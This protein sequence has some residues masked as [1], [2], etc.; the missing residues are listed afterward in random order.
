[1]LIDFA[2]RKELVMCRISGLLL[3]VL[4]LTADRA[5][6][7]GSL[8]DLL[9]PGNVV[10]DP[11]RFQLERG[12]ARGLDFPATA[13]TPGFTY[14]YDPALGDFRR[15]SASLGPAFLERADTV[16]KGR[17]D[18]GLSMLYAA[19]DEIDGHGL[20]GD[21][22]TIISEAPGFV[23][24]Q[25]A[26]QVRFDNFDLTA[27]SWYG[28]ATYGITN[29]IDV[30]LLL[31]LF[32][33][34]LSVRRT[35][36]FGA[37]VRTFSGSESAFGVGDIQVRGKYLI[38]RRDPLRAAVGLAFRLPTGNEDDFHGIGDF[39]ITPSGVLS[40]V[41]GRNDVHASLGLEM[42]ADEIERSRVNYGAG[43]SV[44]IIQRLTGNLDIIGSSQFVKEDVDVPVNASA[45]ALA[46]AVA[47]IPGAD[48][49][50]TGFNS[51]IV[52]LSIDRTDIVDVAVGAKVAIVGSLVGFATVIVPITD[53]GVRSDFVPAGGLEI[54]F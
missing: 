43:V 25:Q 10:V 47:R 48:V 14:Q 6:L 11:V 18:V 34:D 33:T 49:T 17:F 21:S 3:L 32:Y 7:A 15:T 20:D 1:M 35:D 23:G 40:Y 29:R 37:D 52:S 50:A 39:T 16:G 4:A 27:F 9:G 44:G 28:S 45:Q 13:T 30:N 53:D 51:S 8:V 12:L 31:P 41:F 46:P 2:P 42:N 36:A 54:S 24:S 5:A 22:R 38:D 19:P 26:A